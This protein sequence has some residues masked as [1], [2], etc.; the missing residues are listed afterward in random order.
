M[1]S[2]RRIHLCRRSYTEVL[3]DFFEKKLLSSQKIFS[4][5]ERYEKILD[6]IP[7]ECTQ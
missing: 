6:M 3:K 7:D 1:A 5:E 2:L 4:T